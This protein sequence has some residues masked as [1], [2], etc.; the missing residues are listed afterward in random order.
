[1]TDEQIASLFDPRDG[2]TQGLDEMARRFARRIE[3]AAVAPLLERIAALE[4]ENTRLEG[5]VYSPGLWRCAKC[6][7]T[8]V[9]RNLNAHSGTVTARDQPGDKCP[10]CAVNLWRVTERENATENYDAAE[11]L[12]IRLNELEAKLAQRVP[13]GFVLA[14][15]IRLKNA[16][17]LVDMGF[18]VEGAKILDELLSAAP[19]APEQQE[20]TPIDMV[21]H[22]PA[23]GMQHV[24]AP[25]K[26]HYAIEDDEPPMQWDNPP[27]RS[28]LCHDCGHVWRPA[29]VPTNGVAAVKTKGK[30]D[31]PVSQAP[32]AQQAEAQE[33]CGHFMSAGNGRWVQCKAAASY[34]EPLFTRPQ[35][36]QLQALSE[37]EVREAIANE[38]MMYTA[39]DLRVAKAI[40]SA[41]AAKNWAV[42]K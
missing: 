31:S 29:D 8:L 39:P 27:H 11:S 41:L 13:D 23:C 25:E 20:P 24:D 38:G 7:F 32:N 10:N 18:W 12:Q 3:T 5:L 33:P 35:P 37:G 1:M 34:T 22:C 4:A 19:A 26:S 9:Q 42:L 14:P 30:A 40:Q 15:S 28:H 36:A 21:L 16:R 6:K 17:A 2:A